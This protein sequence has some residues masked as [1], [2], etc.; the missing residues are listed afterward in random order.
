M[1]LSK[2][3]VGGGNRLRCMDI[4]DAATPTSA[5]TVLLDVADD[6]VS[7][8]AGKQTSGAWNPKVE[9]VQDD[10][11]LNTYLEN[12]TSVSTSGGIEPLTLEDSVKRDGVT[13]QNATQLFISRGGSQGTV[14]TNARKVLVA[15]VR[16]AN[17]SGSYKQEG[18]KYNRVT[19]EF[20]GFRLSGAF[21]VPASFFNS[22]MTTP[23]SV[24]LSTSFPYG[25]VAFG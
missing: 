8:D 15:P 14:A 13:S 7:T 10:A 21:T 12:Q 24:S 5:G 4:T 18:E 2:N 17:V 22:I 11:T 20:E 6:I 1:G 16:L 23:T 25:R 9:H 3:I 19:L